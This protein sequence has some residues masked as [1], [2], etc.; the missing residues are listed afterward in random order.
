MY[1]LEK[2]LIDLDYEIVWTQILKNDSD[3]SD[4][5]IVMIVGAIHAPV[6]DLTEWLAVVKFTVHSNN[7]GSTGGYVFK[8]YLPSREEAINTL[9]NLLDIMISILYIKIY[10]ARDLKQEMQF[11]ACCCNFLSSD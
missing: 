5:P 1:D 8:K 9:H 2:E 11:E 7:T 6:Q 4:L 3:E 10:P